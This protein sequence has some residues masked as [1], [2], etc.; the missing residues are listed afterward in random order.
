MKNKKKLLGAMALACLLIACVDNREIEISGMVRNLDGKQIVYFQSVDGMF[1]SQS[2]DTLKIHPDSTYTL[3]LPAEQYKRVRFVLKGNRELGSLITGKRKL[4]VNLDGAA[5]NGIDVKGGDEKEMEIS[6]ILD[7]LNRDV[8]NLR[9]RRGDRWSI[10]DDTVA[11]SVIAKLKA[12]ALAMD[13]K[14]KG[15]DEDLYKKL[16]QDVRLQLMLAFQNQLLGVNWKCSE[17]TKQQWLEA[18]EQ[19]KDFCADDDIDSPFSMAF[20]DVVAYNAGINYFV[21]GEQ[22]SEIDDKDPDKLSFYDYEHHLNGRSREAA[23]A[24]LFLQD[25][26]A[27]RNN[28]AII[29]L[30]E[31]F[32]ELY[33]Q[34]AWMPLVDR[35]VAKNRAFNET[36]MSD[37]IHFPDIENVKTFNE[38][39]DRYKGKVVLLDI[40]ATWCGSCRDAF[41]YVK[42]L[43]EYVKQR[44]DIV[45]LYLSID[46][47]KD[48]AKWRKMAAFYDLAG[49]H[50]RIQDA[51]HDEIYKTFG[52]ERETLYIPRYVIFDKNGKIC[53]SVAA[54]PENLAMLKSQL[55]EAARVK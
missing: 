24:Q 8:W 5:E 16:K 39:I 6:T 2:F 30:A 1:N 17:A 7:R 26:M 18:W 29:P 53:C 10:A 44:D 13:E 42:P 22:I 48:D 27:E 37:H 34:S 35:A 38:V 28:P 52:D 54:S 32:R 15:V 50:V 21:K 31:R 40:W 4:V 12:D 47:Q 25:E 9:A 36:K 49:D 41:A 51:F 11:T 46:R 14:M 19:M 23:M 3:T 33:P 45:L 55:E 20:Y 43:Q